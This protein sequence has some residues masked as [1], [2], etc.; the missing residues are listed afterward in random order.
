MKQLLTAVFVFFSTAVGAIADPSQLMN[1]A[2][3]SYNKIDGNSQ[4]VRLDI[5]KEILSKL[6]SI[7]VNHPASN[8][9]RSI[10]T[11][12]DIGNF[13]PSI[14]KDQYINELTS[15]Y[16][17]VCEVSPS[18]T[19]L[20]YVSLNNGNDLCKNAETFSD[21]DR[22][23]SQLNNALGVF[24]SQKSGEGMSNLVVTV[25]R[26]CTVGY[27]L[28][29]WNKD[30]YSSIL[31]E[32]LLG[33][34]LVD[35]AR[36]LIQDMTSPYFK[37]KGV[38]GLK[39]ASGEIADE[40]YLARLDTYIADNIGNDGDWNSPKETFLATVELRMY[41]VQHSDITITRRY[42]R[43]AIQKYRNYG[44]K[45]NCDVE[46]ANFLFNL[47]L[48]F[49]VALVSIPEGRNDLH[50]LEGLLNEFAVRPNHIYSQCGGQYSNYGLAADIHGKILAQ[51]GLD[52]ATEFRN[53]LKQRSMS[54]EELM[55]EFFA[56]TN[57]DEQTLI[58]WYLE[59]AKYSGPDYAAMSVYTRLVDFGNVCESSIILFQNLALTDRFEAAVE[60]MLESDSIDGNQKYS[61]GDE[62]LE[63]LL[64]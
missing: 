37:F 47:M 51:M 19:C 9:A 6:D 58:S 22:A 12:Q 44:D 63:L 50:G 5:Y 11:R 39:K 24:T 62:D 64:K 20:A 46:Y 28:P 27:D 31:V 61:C 30:Y 53:L 36:A 21:L 26:Q 56:R 43:D 54:P 1:E 33:V 40:S 23:F 7:L 35:N 48:D 18:Y 3:S 25:A 13:N 16:Q 34:G 42:M 29:E 38:L 60:Y 4:K 14:V 41:A 52:K 8:E 17:T 49:Q 57:V 15:Y 32:M 45:R 2:I 10:L 55:N 59:D